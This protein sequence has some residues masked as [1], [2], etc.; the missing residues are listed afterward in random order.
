MTFYKQSCK[1]ELYT[2]EVLRGEEMKKLYVFAAA[3]V[4]MGAIVVANLSGTNTQAIRDARDCNN[5]SIV[6]CGALSQAEWLKNYDANKSKDLKAIYDHYGI[7]RDDMT[8]KTS[9]VK[10]GKVYKDGRVVVDGKTVATGAHSVG[11]NYA[12]NS[13][14]VTING[15][16]YYERTDASGFGHDYIDAFVLMRNGEFYRAIL[17]SCSNPVVAVPT[18]KPKPEP[19]C[20]C[21]SVTAEKKT[22]D[23]YKFTAAAKAENGAKIVKYT[24]DFGDGKKE[25]TTSTTIEHTYE[26]PGN[27]KITL[28]V[29]VMINGKIKTID[30]AKCKTEITIEEAPKYTCDGLTARLIKKE[31][32]SYEFTLTYTAENGATLKNVD[33]DFGDGTKTTFDADEASVV[34]HSYAKAGT[35]TTTTTLHFNEAN[36]EDQKC[37]VTVSPATTEVPP[38]EETP[39]ELP[40][41]GAADAIGAGVGLSAL[42]GAGYYWMASRR[43]LYDATK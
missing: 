9:Q 10:I 25:S 36:V 20:A 6:Y 19:S 21:E 43:A 13:K 37:E 15:K 39:K 14:K 30:G 7:S 1:F 27:Y 17:T 11:R 24:F 35:Y 3:I 38:K 23:T 31:D 26:K 18:P 28:T 5:N 4:A 12:K 42:I 16:T 32:R 29:D 34:E 40:K 22:R 33:Y 41:T 8:G 2:I